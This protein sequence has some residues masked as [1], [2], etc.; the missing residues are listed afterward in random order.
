MNTREQPPLAYDVSAYELAPQFPPG[1]REWDRP[2]LERELARRVAREKSRRELHVCYYRIGHTLAFQLPVAA[3]PS[4][5]ELPQGIPGRSDYPWLTWLAWA[6][7]E[8][9]RVL[10]AAWRQLRDEEAGAMLQRELAALAGWENFLDESNKVSLVTG[11]LAACLALA[12]A[13]R[14]GWR[15]DELRRAQAAARSLVERDVSPWFQK[16]WAADAPLTPARL[17]NIPTIA[18]LRAA[19][20]ARVIGH[21]QAPAFEQRAGQAVGAWCA[22][23]MGEGHHT[24][25]AAYDGYLMDSATEWIGRAPGRSDL[26]ATT[27][28]ACASLV[29]QWLHQTL[30]GRPDLHAPLGDTEPEMPFWIT[31][32]LRMAHWHDWKEAG[33]LARR[34]PLARLPAAALALENWPFLS[35]VSSPPAAGVREYPGAATM[36]TGWDSDDLLVAVG[37]SR[38]AMGHLHNDAGHVVIGWQGRFW[39]TDPGYQQYRPGPEREFTVGPQSHNAP[40]IGGA[41]QDVH[42]AR[43]LAA[44]CGDDGAQHVAIEL[45]SCYK[46]LP[47]QAT[48]RR[49]IWL[50]PD[51]RAVVVRDEFKGLPPGIEVRTFWQGAAHMAWAFRD[52]WARLADGGRALWLGAMPGRL[53]AARLTRH[54]GSRGPLTLEH[55]AA[56]AEGRGA[57]WWIMQCDGAA[58]WTPPAVSGDDAKVQVKAIGKE[59]AKTINYEP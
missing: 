59:V 27:R 52:G 6:L 39:I 2:D 24:E 53:E 13:D 26:V 49:D 34:F 15:I 30:P 55:V 3:K 36:R 10:H 42:A 23:R 22:L 48:V 20:L 1:L 8:R 9:W 17:H 35:Q 25:G 45:S 33:W 7:E 32:M 12:V 47:K 19:Q 57:Q 40:V 44:K 46:S 16:T 38:C 28:P 58:G 56:L 37:L 18:L 51:A 5:C 14:A 4:V 54:V 31:A 41:A 11:H 43:L 29:Q 50:M 21:P